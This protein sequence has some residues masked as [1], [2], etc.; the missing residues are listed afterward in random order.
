MNILLIEDD[1]DFTEEIKRHVSALCSDPNYSIADCVESA[2]QLIE[3]SFFDLIILDL[4]LPSSPGAM[5]SDPQHGRNLLDTALAAAPGTPVFMLTG[6]SAEQFLHEIIQLST[7]VDV[8]GQGKA[9]PLIGFLPKHRLDRL[10]EVIKPYID[11]C[12]AAAEIEL[13]T[14]DELTISESRLIK[15]F[16]ASVGGVFCNVSRLGGGLSGTSVFKLGVIDSNGAPIHNSVAKIGLPADI[17]DEVERHD[18]YISRLQPNATPRLVKVLNHGAKVTSGV[19]YSLATASELNGYSFI[20]EGSDIVI[21]RIT[22]CLQPWNDAAINQRITVG[23]IRRTFIDDANFNA[24]KNLITHDWAERFENNLVLVKWGCVH[25]D[26]HG[27][28]VLVTSES[29]PVLIDYGDVGECASSRDPVTFELSVFFHPE[30]PLKD[31]EWPTADEAS[32]WGTPEFVTNT[33]SSPNY[34]NKCRQWSEVIS[35]GKRERAAVAYGYLAR[36]LK[37][38]GTNKKRVNDFLLGV[39]RLFDNA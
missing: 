37:Y 9:L 35:A 12:D 36:Q 27:L 34:F 11:G 7:Q 2:T 1:P 31:S 17:K 4:K 3:T 30:G 33:C 22:T 13:N 19:F 26:L 25:G 6:S 20:H 15:I 5:D 10:D 32:L 23:D 28:N 16:T 39:K 24:V 8:W 38:P 21:E 14:H 29:I 18:R